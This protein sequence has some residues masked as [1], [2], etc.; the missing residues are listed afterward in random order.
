MANTLY[1]QDFYAWTIQTAQ[2]LKEK[3]FNK[4]DFEHLV[5]EL[6]SMGASEK[7]E[8]RSRLKQLIMHLLKLKYQP[9][10]INTASW[11]RSVRNQRRELFIHLKDNPSLK[12]R[13]AESIDEIYPIAVSLASEE[14]GIKEETFSLECPFTTSQILDDNFYP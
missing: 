4:V 12:P 8:L 5:E 6:E 14:T 13:V 1:D 9:D 11:V 3:A 10:Y 7:R 2:A